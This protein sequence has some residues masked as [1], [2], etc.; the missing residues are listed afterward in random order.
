MWEYAGRHYDKIFEQLL[1]HI[2]ITV[3]ALFIS[4]VIA[5]P[6]GF[7]LSKFKRVSSAVLL[8]LGIIYTIPS[9]GLFALLIPLLGL[10]LKSAIVALVAYSQLILVR[11]T[12]S[13]FQNVDPG[14][15]EA[16]RGMGLSP[17]QV[18]WKIQLPLGLPVIL[19]G[20]RI[21][22]VSIIG[23]ATIAAWI[24]AGGIGVLLFEGLYQYSMPKI[25]WGTICVSLL[26]ILT[27]QIIYWF[28]K[29]LARR[30]LGT[31]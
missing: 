19:A 13:G 22:A 17:A 12:I 11:N 4:L 18:F 7:V 29:R 6:L 3:L 1:Q 16:G 26:A 21:A 14:V 10:G 24:N 23:I 28:E 25:L 20:V 31:P 2:E 8:V 9:M 27:N 5:L 15:L 30:A